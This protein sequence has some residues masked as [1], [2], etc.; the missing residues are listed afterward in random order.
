MP[1]YVKVNFGCFYMAIRFA[2]KKI[3]ELGNTE[4]SNIHSLDIKSKSIGVV[5]LVFALCY[6]HIFIRKVYFVILFFS[7]A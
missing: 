4:I 6:V 1:I 3:N 2:G 5:Y 7:L